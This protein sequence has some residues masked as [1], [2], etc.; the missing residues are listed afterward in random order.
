MHLCSALD[1]AMPYLPKRL[2]GC[3]LDVFLEHLMRYYSGHGRIL[4]TQF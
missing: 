4:L 3:T 2:L 1:L